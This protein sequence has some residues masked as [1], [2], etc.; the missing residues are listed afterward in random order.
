MMLK[1]IS[2]KV[3]V[4]SVLLITF[5]SCLKNRN[6]V[7]I[8]NS[9]GNAVAVKVGPT[10]FGTVKSISTTEYKKVPDGEQEITGDV[11]GKITFEKR[12][13]AKYTININSNGIVTLIKDN[14]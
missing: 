1:N 13:K 11:N 3:L 4:F 12:S 9:F 6:E 8:R 7:R 2:G 5:T 10:D 14:K